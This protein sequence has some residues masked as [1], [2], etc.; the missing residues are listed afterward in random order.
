MNDKFFFVDITNI[1]L[2]KIHLKQPLEAIK[3]CHITC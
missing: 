1:V 3:L 2:Q